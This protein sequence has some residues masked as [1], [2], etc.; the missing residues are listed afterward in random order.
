MTAVTAQP[1]STPL[2]TLEV[3]LP[4]IFSNLLPD[5]LRQTVSHRFHTEQEQ[6]QSTEHLQRA[7]NVHKHAPLRS[8]YSFFLFFVHIL[9]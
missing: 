9:L 3:R 7:K 8:S 4:K 2:G 5:A 6:T 1:S